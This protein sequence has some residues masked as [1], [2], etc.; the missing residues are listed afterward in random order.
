MGSHA[1]TLSEASDN[2]VQL[3]S[4]G[5]GKFVAPQAVS[6]DPGSFAMSVGDFS[7]VN[8]SA[9]SLAMGMTG[10]DVKELLA[11]QASLASE[12]IQTVSGAA[13]SAIE[14]VTGAVTQTKATEIAAASGERSW[15]RYIPYAAGLA[16]LALLWRRR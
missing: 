14:S 16:A 5:G 15:E 11:Q 7:K 10:A 3:D 6:S 2:R 4:T 12:Q 1:Y 13:K 8:F 9:E